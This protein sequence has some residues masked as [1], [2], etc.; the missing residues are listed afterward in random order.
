MKRK[1]IINLI[2]GTNNPGK[3]REIKD[4]LPKNL[5]IYSPK[6]LNFKSPKETGRTFEEN[7]LLKAKFF[8][9]KANMICLADDSGI[10]IDSLNKLP[11]VYSAR[12]GGKNNKE[13]KEEK[14]SSFLLKIE[15]KNL[16]RS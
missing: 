7:S 12:W 1:K 10:E 3:L 2:V 6:E 9:K 4:L 5:I 13:S 11:G 16:K 14:K 15:S 8:S